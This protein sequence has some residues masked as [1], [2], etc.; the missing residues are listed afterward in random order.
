MDDI[1][2]NSLTVYTCLQRYNLY[3]CMVRHPSAFPKAKVLAS[4][5]KYNL[6]KFNIYLYAIHFP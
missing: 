5:L 2:L 3:L 6:L 4:S 1:I